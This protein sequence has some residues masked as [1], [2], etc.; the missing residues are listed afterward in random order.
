EHSV[1]AGERAAP[2]D[3]GVAAAAGSYL[4]RSAGRSRGSPA[5][6]RPADPPEA[7]QT[8]RN[9]LHSTVPATGRGACV[10]DDHPRLVGTTRTDPADSRRLRMAVRAQRSLAARARRTRPDVAAR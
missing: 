10:Q 7:D 1:P 3:I 4:R 2:G 8:L 9:D 6:R 5:H